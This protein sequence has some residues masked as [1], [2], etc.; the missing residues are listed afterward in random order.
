MLFRSHRCQF[1][2]ACDGK[3]DMGTEVPAWTKATK[4][5]AVAY[6]EF[7]QGERPG[8]IPNS[9]MYY[10]TLWVDPDWSNKFRRVAT[11]GAHEFYSAN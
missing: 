9:A 8:V 3:S 1:T 2:F 10:H 5:A 4:M 7:K 6:S 11:I